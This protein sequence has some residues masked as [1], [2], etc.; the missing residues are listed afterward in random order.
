MVGTAANS[1]N[2]RL[3]AASRGQ[4]LQIQPWCIHTFT[5][6]SLAEQWG[7]FQAGSKACLFLV[8]PFTLRFLPEVCL[9]KYND[10]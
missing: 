2:E 3:W 5:G 10:F 1:E 4:A 9:L 7:V 8:N 6:C